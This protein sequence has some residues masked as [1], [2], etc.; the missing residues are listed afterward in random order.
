MTKGEQLQVVKIRLFASLKDIIGSNEI[1]LKV[2]EGDTI[3]DLKESLFQ[4]YPS[5]SSLK[6]PLIFALNHKVASDS[7]VLSFQDEIALFPPVSGGS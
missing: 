4:I 5:L 6:F 7:T 3:A 1:L 2:N